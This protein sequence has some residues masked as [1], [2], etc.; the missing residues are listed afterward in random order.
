MRS[1]RRGQT[2]AL[3]GVMLCFCTWATTQAAPV[4]PAATPTLGGCSVYPADNV[5]NV[6]VDTLPRDARSDEYVNQMGATSRAHADF[7]SGIYPDPGGGPIGIPFMVVP[8]TQ[9]LASIH[10]TAYGDESDP[11][12]FPIPQNAPIEHGSDHHVLVLRQGE[13]KLYELYNAA[14]TGSGWDADSGAVYTFT[15]NSP[16]RPLGWTSADAAGLPILPGLAR[17]EEV[18]AGEINHA[19][20]F[21]SY[22][23]RPEYVWPARHQAQ[24]HP[25]VHSP[26]MGQRFRLKASFSIDTRFSA[27]TQ[28]I[29]RAL[30]KYGMILAD[31]G[32]SWFVSGA[33]NAG[34]NNDALHQ[35]D[36]YV[37]GSDF[38]A[39]DTSSLIVNV[40]SWQA[41]V[42]P[43]DFKAWVY[44]PLVRR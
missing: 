35:L 9:P 19:L 16:L 44:L 21:T 1:Q 8:A 5:W 34:W 38:E 4:G 30:K 11:G 29:L 24:Y 39:V 23:T 31:N 6:P 17:Y 10:Y 3:L 18:A 2:A 27:Q 36:T 7:G 33:P 22:T 13:C 12:P 25:S 42:T 14:P 41:R 15:Q 20:R 43:I 37:K 26:P 40:N 28:V 32:S